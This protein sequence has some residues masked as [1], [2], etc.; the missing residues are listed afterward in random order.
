MF[1]QN[2]SRLKTFGCTATM[3][4]VWETSGANAVVREDIKHTNTMPINYYH[5]LL[6]TATWL[7]SYTTSIVCFK[8]DKDVL[9]FTLMTNFENIL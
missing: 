6:I 4:A 3:V 9:Q 2:L 7:D 8:G 5:I 1:K